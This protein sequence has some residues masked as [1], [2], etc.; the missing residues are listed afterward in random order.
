V[1]GLAVDLNGKDP[2]VD[3]SAAWAQAASGRHRISERHRVRR[4]A[5]KPDDA[6][7]RIRVRVWL[8]CTGALLAMAVAIYWALG[9]ERSSE[10]GFRSAPSGLPPLTSPAPSSS[11]A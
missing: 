10:A 2:L 9:H 6:R 5:R 3:S 7:A 4:R 11:R 8:A 1:F